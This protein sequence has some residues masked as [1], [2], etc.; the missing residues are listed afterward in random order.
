MARTM[1]DELKRPAV[2]VTVG[3]LAILVAGIFFVGMHQW[4]HSGASMS[5][6]AAADR[7]APAAAAA[8]SGAV[9]AVERKA[10][11]SVAVKP[12]VAWQTPKRLPGTAFAKS[13]QGT[14]IDGALRADANGNLIVD[15]HV[16]DFFDY[17]LST[18]GEVSPEVAVAQMEKL[19][20]G[21]LPPQALDQAMTLLGDYL[22][23]KEKALALSQQAI[24]VPADQQT[25]QFQLQVLRSSL[26]KL[27]EL[28]RET[29]PA[30]AVQAFFGLQEAY[31][32]YTIKTLQ[33]EQRQDLT[34][35][36]KAQMIANARDNLPPII[37]H[38]QVQLTRNADRSA[39]I[40]KVEKTASSPDDAAEQLRQMGVS[41]DQIQNVVN[42][43]TAQ[44][45][46]NQN[47]ATYLQDR[48]Q[49]E[50]AGLAPEDKTKALQDLLKRDFSSEEARTQARLRDL[51]S[52]GTSDK[53]VTTD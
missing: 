37:R 19:A 26:A 4:Q 51:A 6:V 42:Y 45:Q 39:A 22:N 50:Q 9:S 7:T 44:K 34:N 12:K 49:I 15:L 53:N 3:V 46:F 20:R 31:G 13:L 14:N 1:R 8:A 10:A 47:Y 28:R 48:Q 21:S 25:P 43:M 41:S 17:F 2:L 23:Y 27:K 38:T 52:Q 32:D 30:D 11:A 5:M 36:E 40:A 24:N 33:I 35:S 18:V 29:M 16:K